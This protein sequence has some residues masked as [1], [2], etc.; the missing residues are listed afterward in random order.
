MPLSLQARYG[1]LR[2]RDEHPG[3]PQPAWRLDPDPRI[4]DTELLIDV[5]RLNV[6]SASFRQ[7][8][9]EAGGDPDRV[10]GRIREIV[11]ERGKLHNPV[12]G[13]G[14]MLIGAVREVG[15]VFAESRPVRVGTRVASLIS[16][17][18]TPL[19]LERI[20][21]VDMHHGQVRVE[22]TAVLFESSP[23]AE[24]PTDIAEPIALAALDVAGAPARTR[25]MVHRGDAVLLLGGGGTS[26]LLSLYEA[27]R[28]AGPEGLI[29]VVDRAAALADVR[30]T[31]LAD[32]LVE[33]DATDA[34]AT[35]E[36]VFAA[37]GREADVTLNVVNVPGTELATILLTRESGAVLFFS[38]ATSFTAAALGAEGLGRATT[39][40]I[41]NG[42]MPDTGA[43]ALGVL[44]ECAPVRAVFERRYLGA[45]ARS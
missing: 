7:L 18:L 20:V 11:A 25:V 8:A 40:L 3:F 2:V 42:H 36:A 17:T 31:G 30:T 26:G 44:R 45:G 12:T 39:M 21:D 24:L 35:V 41:G 14:G 29:M 6:D 32:I 9:E 27:R 5:E 38:M 13:S 22:G 37:G 4:S 33:A 23:F 19:T 28:A 1:L 10:A 43:I 15:S 16:L 34:V